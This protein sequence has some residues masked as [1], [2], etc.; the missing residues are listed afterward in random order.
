ML[1][2]CFLYVPDVVVFFVFFYYFNEKS[3]LCFLG[4]TTFFHY[5]TATET[6]ETVSVIKGNK[7]NA[8]GLKNPPHPP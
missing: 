3:L 1:F 7:L 6:F 2:I 5:L 8:T 4:G